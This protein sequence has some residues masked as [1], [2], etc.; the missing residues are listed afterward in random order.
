MKHEVA[1]TEVELKAEDDP[2]RW[3]GKYNDILMKSLMLKDTCEEEKHRLRQL[4]HPNV[5]TVV[6]FVTESERKLY[7]LMDCTS[8]MTL[9]EL[10]LQ[11][12]YVEDRFSYYRQIAEGMAYLHKHNFIHGCLQAKF[13]YVTP[14]GRAVIGQLARATL[15][16]LDIYDDDVSQVME[17]PFKVVPKNSIR[18][19]PKETNESGLMTQ[20]T[21]VYSFG[22]LIW[23]TENALCQLDNPPR[24]HLVPYC[25]V[26]H[27]EIIVVQRQRHTLPQSPHC[28]DWLDALIKALMANPYCRRPS[29]PEVLDC[30][31]KREPYNPEMKLGEST[32]DSVSSNREQLKRITKMIDTE[33][34]S[35]GFLQRGTVYDQHMRRTVLFTDDEREMRGT[36]GFRSRRDTHH[37]VS[38]TTRVDEVVCYDTSGNPMSDYPQPRLRVDTRDAEGGY[39][40]PRHQMPSDPIY[41]GCDVPRHW[42]PTD[43][44]YGH[45][46]VPRNQ[47][48]TDPV[49]GHYDVPRHQMPTDP[50]YGG[51]DVPRHG[52]PT[53]PVYG[54]LLSGVGRLWGL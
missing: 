24:T 50:I 45:F 2:V 53:D 3:P 44:V 1:C 38:F 7:M 11:S 8:T 43:P 31:Q 17:Q 30:L 41:G 40:V 29:F 6:R 37:Y 5:A 36:R 28:P 33:D 46:D 54:V 26:K 16:H 9:L 35:M 21:D 20:K 39:D 52:M 19:L 32:N 51:C 47:M 48:P 15:I 22:V 49:Y 42:M 34:E 18:W 10:M 27:N 23:E 14:N 12:S 4:K 25:H 13:I